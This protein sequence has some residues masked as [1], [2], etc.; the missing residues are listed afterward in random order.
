MMTHEGGYSASYV[1]VCGVEVLSEM[2]GVPVD[3]IHEFHADF[4][5]MPEHEQTQWQVEAVKAVLA[6]Q[7]L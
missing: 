7:S 6:E 5:T 4:D 3:V 1:P 2:S